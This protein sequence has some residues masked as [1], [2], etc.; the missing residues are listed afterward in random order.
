MFVLLGP[1]IYTQDQR[2]VATRVFKFK[3]AWRN[4]LHAPATERERHRQCVP[5]KEMLIKA[6][7]FV[8]ASP[9]KL[10]GIPAPHSPKPLL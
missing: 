8:L 2:P 5:L 9:L 7:L 1:V 4:E 3:Q 6:L 10:A